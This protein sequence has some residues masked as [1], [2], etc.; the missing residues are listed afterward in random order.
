MKK[1]TRELAS[2]FVEAWRERSEEDLSFYGGYPDAIRIVEEACVVIASV[3][4]AGADNKPLLD[5]IPIS[6]VVSAIEEAQRM[7]DAGEADTLSA[8]I[9]DAY[10]TLSDES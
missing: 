9:A 1:E 10:Y 3:D 4:R 5:I 6:K 7:V 2:K 8:A